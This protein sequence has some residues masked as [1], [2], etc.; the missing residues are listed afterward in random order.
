MTRDS[1]LSKEAE[2][3]HTIHDCVRAGGKVL[4]PV[5]AVGRVQEF[6]VMLDAYWQRMGLTV[7]V[8]RT[9]FR[10]CSLWWL[11]SCA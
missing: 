9:L 8:R 11:C 10:H 3:L 7:R 1:K 2:L 5:F 6:C 4:I